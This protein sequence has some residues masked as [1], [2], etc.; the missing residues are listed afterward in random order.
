[1]Q[2][3]IQTQDMQVTIQTNDIQ[4]TIQTQDIQVTIQTQDIQVTIQTQDI[5]VTIQ[6]QDMQ[7]TIQTNDIQVT[8]QTQDIQVTIQIQDIQVTIQTQDIQVTLQTQDIQV[9][10]QTQDMQLALIGEKVTD[11]L[12]KQGNTDKDSNSTTQETLYYGFQGFT[13][14][15]SSE[16]TFI[17][18]P[19]SVNGSHT[20]LRSPFVFL[21]ISRAVV[22]ASCGD[23]LGL[24]C[25][26]NCSANAWPAP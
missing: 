9:T 3:T 4:V 17:K 10:I 12:G 26:S 13:P 11:T 19:S 23:I 5:Q 15:K 8:I 25:I 6:T 1:M 24:N 14:E 2:V 18:M 16:Y 20:Y 22:R 21:N 7:V